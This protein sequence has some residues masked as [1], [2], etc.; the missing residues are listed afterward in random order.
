[1]RRWRKGQQGISSEKLQAP[2][3]A[4][5]AEKRSVEVVET[6][7]EPGADATL[8]AAAWARAIQARRPARHGTLETD[9]TL[10]PLSV[11]FISHPSLVRSLS[12]MAPRRKCNVC[13]SQQWHKEPATGIVVC[14]EGHVLQVCASSSGTLRNPLGPVTPW[15]CDIAELSKRD[16]RDV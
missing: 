1:M 2:G 16:K 6:S 5:D 10:Y 7:R 3:R 4:L 8:V 11:C 15:I 13:G 9:C 12:Q 14:S